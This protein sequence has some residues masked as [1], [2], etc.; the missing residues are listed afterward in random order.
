IINMLV[1]N[2]PEIIRNK[3]EK[4]GMKQKEFASMLS[5]KESLIH[6][7]ETGA[8]E[9]S[10]NMARRFERALGVSLIQEYKEEHKKLKAE[11]GEDLTIGDMIKV[12]KKS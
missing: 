5:E 3:R 12:R 6:K 1:E 9:P 2:Y 7:I 4:L 8:F 11:E 10:L